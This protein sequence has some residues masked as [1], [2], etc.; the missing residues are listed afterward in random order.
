MI[1]K[2]NSGAEFRSSRFHEEYPLS[3]SSTRLGELKLQMLAEAA[4]DT[5]SRTENILNSAG[6]TSVGTGDSL[7]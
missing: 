1:P 4:K 2:P 3:I 5:R 7:C 6:N